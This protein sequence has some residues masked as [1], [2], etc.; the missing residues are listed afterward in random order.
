[1]MSL[2]HVHK[3][4]GNTED[5]VQAY[6][7]GV[8]ANPSLGEAWWSLADLK[9]YRFSDAEVA[10][11]QAARQTEDLTGRDSAALH[12]ALGKAFEDRPRTDQAFAHYRTGTI[13]AA[14]TSRSKPSASNTSARSSGARL[15]PP[16]QGRRR[17]GVRR[18]NLGLFSCRLAALG[19][20]ADRPDPGLAQPSPGHDG[21]ATGPRL[22]SR[23]RARG[24]PGVHRPDDGART[25]CTGPALPR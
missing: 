12:F 18:R 20:D 4:L 13:C 25:G 24:L 6:R 1:M 7:A 16:R 5:R 19:F 23:A 8:A 10:E 3:A 17:R 14:C 21:V 11:M 9:T 2:G 22:R 15:R